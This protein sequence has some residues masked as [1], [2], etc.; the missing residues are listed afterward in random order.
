MAL[1]RIHS[2]LP[3]HIPSVE[4]SATALCLKPNSWIRKRGQNLCWMWGG[5]IFQVAPPPCHVPATR[6]RNKMS[7]PPHWFNHLRT[8]MWRSV[9]LWGLK[10]MRWLHWTWRNSDAADGNEVTIISWVVSCVLGTIWLTIGW[11]RRPSQPPTGAQYWLTLLTINQLRLTL[12]GWLACWFAASTSSATPP[13]ASN[14]ALY[15]TGTTLQP[16]LICS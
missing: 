4:H 13:M 5:V 10:M 12:T 14:T 1:E 8:R 2:T 16:H 3:Q 15:G 9:S 11:S 6:Q 7:P